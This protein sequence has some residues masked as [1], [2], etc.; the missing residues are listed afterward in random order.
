MSWSAFLR[1]ARVV[2]QNVRGNVT[3]CRHGCVDGNRGGGRTDVCCFHELRPAVVGLL[4]VYHGCYAST[5]PAYGASLS[6]PMPWL[7]AWGFT[8]RVRDRA[9]DS[10]GQFHR[11]PVGTC[12]PARGDWSIR[13]VVSG[14]RA[15][16]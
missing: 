9:S 12:R 4:R 1:I 5:L 2:Q 13:L 15:V 7:H 6:D 16:G 11:E 10:R 14:W 3:R 8:Q